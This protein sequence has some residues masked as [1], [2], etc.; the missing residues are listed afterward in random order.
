MR[1]TKSKTFNEE[2]SSIVDSYDVKRLFKEFVKKIL[3]KKEN[4]M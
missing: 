4:Y 3:G 2:H 1:S